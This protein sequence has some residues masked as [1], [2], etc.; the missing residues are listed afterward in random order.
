MTGDDVP[1]A[2]AAASEA[3]A[4]ALAATP[5][6][7]PW[8]DGSA[9]A[10]LWVGFSSGLDS[11]VLLHALSHLPGVAATHID[12]GL[13]ESEERRRHCV[14][15]AKRLGVPCRTHSVRLHGGNQENA[16]RQARYGVWRQ[17][18]QRHDVLALAHHADDQFETRLWQ[19][20]TGREPGG[21]PTARAVGEGQLLRPLLGLRRR[22]LI[23]Y[24]KRWRLR[25][26]EDP[27]NADPRFD[28]NYIRALLAPLIEQRFPA[29]VERLAAPRPP[30][31]PVAPLPARSADESGIR[32]WLANAGL[33][34]ARGAVAEIERQ[35]AAAPSRNPRVE[36][37]PDIAAWRY[38]EHWHL[39]RETARCD[40]GS[41]AP[42]RV[43]QEQ[44]SVEGR[45]GWQ[46]RPWGLAANTPYSVR[47]RSGGERLK[48]AGRNVTKSVKA[49][50]Q[51]G[52]VPPWQRGK[53]PLI[54]DRE[55]RLLAL[56]GIAVAADAARPQGLLPVWSPA[57][58]E[59]TGR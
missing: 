22:C 57:S 12:H 30:P 31:V 46:H 55:D 1:S 29:A 21:M 23:A 2:D 27:S 38:R 47:W 56:P 48:P 26:I 35:S 40:V 15:V 53:W 59:L 42:G 25:W 34:L 49:L 37:A 58:R 24:A 52:R 14:A 44:R 20:F 36:V 50:F 33:P 28:R 45:L 16:A 32:R 7:A 41:L 51:E 5:E 3:V 4:A 39:I 9:G 11:T 17:M 13:A 10:T 8:Y 54:V 43:G 19:M 6:L 18:L